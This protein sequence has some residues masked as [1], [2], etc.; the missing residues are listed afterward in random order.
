M[1]TGYMADFNSGTF[2]NANNETVTGK[3]MKF[4]WTGSAYII[5]AMVDGKYLHA[6]NYDSTII[7]CKK[8]D[9]IYTF[10]RQSDCKFNTIGFIEE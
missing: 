7:E 9:I 1:L 8:G 5:T 6:W 10:N 3:T 4:E 2:F